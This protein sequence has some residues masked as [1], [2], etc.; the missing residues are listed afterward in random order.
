[1]ITCPWCGTSYSAF[2]SNCQ[3]CGGP[4]PAAAISAEPAAEPPAPPAAPRLIASQYVWRLLETDGWAIAALVFLI[5]GGTFTLV[6][7]LL[8]LLLVTAFVGAP[9][10]VFGLIFLTAGLVLGRRRYQAA[11]QVVD[12]LRHGAAVTGHILEVAENYQVRVN[13]QHPWIIRYQF[14][15]GSQ[16]QQGQV[17]TLTRPG[18]ALQPGRPAC[19]LYLPQAPAANTLYPHP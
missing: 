7:G 1:M 11:Q 17:S 13:R 12:V 18:P 6:G 10:L 15:A 3:R 19:I 8:T 5:L 14:P 9:L 4:L 2:Q 16:I